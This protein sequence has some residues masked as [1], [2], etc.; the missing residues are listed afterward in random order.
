MG[1]SKK[2]GAKRSEE[3]TRSIERL[4]AYLPRRLV[5]TLS[6]EVHSAGECSLEKSQGAILLADLS[7]FTSLCAQL[8]KRHAQ[9]YEEL[10]RSLNQLLVPVVESI[11]NHGGD[12]LKF[13]GDA[14][15]AYW[16]E[17]ETTPMRTAVDAA[18]QS[19]V[20]SIEDI[21]RVMA[22]SPSFEKMGLKQCVVA[23][24]LLFGRL[25]GVRDRWDWSLGGEG[26]AEI[27]HVLDHAEDDLKQERFPILVGRSGV[28]YAAGSGELE[29]RAGRYVVL[30]PRPMAPILP[31]S[32]PTISNP[33]APLQA[34]LGSFTPRIVRDAIVE[35]KDRGPSIEHRPVS[36]LML[37]IPPLHEVSPD[38]ANRIVRLIQS[39]V[40]DQ[41]GSINKISVDDKGAIVLAVFGMPVRRQTSED[42]SERVPPPAQC[43]LAAA[44][45]IRRA[46]AVMASR[47]E[48]AYAA[49]QGIASGEVVLSNLG[50]ERRRE[51]T[52]LSDV[53]NRSVRLMSA[54]KAHKVETDIA[55]DSETALSPSIVNQCTPCGQCVLKGF[56]DEPVAVFAPKA[57]VWIPLDGP[58][59]AGDRLIGRDA[60]RE[61]MKRFVEVRPGSDAPRV[62][63]IS[64]DRGAGRSA[65]L[66]EFT[67][68]A[69]TAGWR[70]LYARGEEGLKSSS[71]YILRAL[72]APVLGVASW[73]NADATDV[74]TA[75]AILTSTPETEALLDDFAPI[76]PVSARRLGTQTEATKV[77]RLLSLS[78]PE[79][80]WALIV[81]DANFSDSDSLRVISGLLGLV[82]P[83]VVYVASGSDGL[84][85]G[86]KC[87]QFPTGPLAQ[88]DVVELLRSRPRL[89]D[90]PDNVQWR[91]AHAT[92]GN[93]VLALEA[94]EFALTDLSDHDGNLV[95]ERTAGLR[96]STDT[97][98]GFL[99]RIDRL[100]GKWAQV[101]RVASVFGETFSL[102]DVVRGW[103]AV[104]GS[105][106]DADAEVRTALAKAVESRVIQ[107]IPAD[108]SE[109]ALPWG[110]FRFRNGALRDAVLHSAEHALRRGVL[111]SM[112]DG[113]P[114]SIAHKTLECWMRD[115]WWSARKDEWPNCNAVLR[116]V[117]PMMEPFHVRELRELL[118]A[119]PPHERDRHGRLLLSH[120]DLAMGNYEAAIQGISDLESVPSPTCTEQD[121]FEVT[122]QL[123]KCWAGQIRPTEIRQL[124]HAW[125]ARTEG[126]SART[127][128]FLRLTE[129]RAL[130]MLNSGDDAEVELTIAW[131]EAQELG[132]EDLV[133]ECALS[134]AESICGV[135]PRRAI[136][137]L[138]STLPYSRKS[139]SAF[140]SRVLSSLARA[141]GS[142]GDLGPALAHAQEALD[143]VRNEAA[144]AR[145]EA[146]RAVASLQLMASNWPDAERCYAE[147]LHIAI[148]LRSP[149]AVADA[150]IGLGDVSRGRRELDHAIAAFR[151]ALLIPIET[152]HVE[153]IRERSLLGLATVAKDLRIP[154][155]EDS[156]GLLAH[157]LLGDSWWEQHRVTKA[158]KE[159]RFLLRGYF[160]ANAGDPTDLRLLR[161]P[162]DLIRETAAIVLLSFRGKSIRQPAW[163][164]VVASLGQ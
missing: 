157:R 66:K 78:G 110:G 104:M 28:P 79:E 106:G 31:V 95:I 133:A 7:G 35:D 112:P 132:E 131:S 13:A 114:E 19:A 18:I 46:F 37:G 87:A 107:E 129:G 71:Y 135:D 67:R 4:A 8:A 36:V 92:G 111:E 128:V 50:S 55:M 75:R 49:V 39:S 137:L 160:R 85:E 41:R 140:L 52:V 152:R 101:V 154:D 93:P 73:Q 120:F 136:R 2:K 144:V 32:E 118:R 109:E 59:P 83:F 48:R 11:L 15:V 51:Y 130:S 161:S 25:G 6:A 16:K 158:R 33:S 151:A 88:A 100:G 125:R 42:A 14:L 89:R 45:V 23:G 134:L 47:R 5:Q 20:T 27:K 115:F 57:R 26:L 60:Q 40:Y 62:A 56:G 148:A 117:S 17:T 155:F 74:A 108:G 162:R 63:L 24:P 86:H 116:M 153:G 119:V 91:I 69:G 150:L 9:G 99:D 43:A 103:R 38:H 94:A 1:K 10:A 65:M 29:L 34:A 126:L 12:V 30:P 143:L 21:R 121:A 76:Y 113:P 81:D 84:F 72:L 149:L 127:R 164:P 70:C 22:G 156:I 3:L 163:L 123:L 159:L 146:V 53:V 68:I 98:H 82:S 90:L 96:L 61:R 141:L 105:G 58:S 80:R 77:A 122:V 64:G 54:A 102:E 138:R 124:I 44:L 147:S 145:R 97:K 139:S 142:V